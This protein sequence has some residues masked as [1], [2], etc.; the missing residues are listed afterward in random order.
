MFKQWRQDDFCDLEH[1]RKTKINNSKQQIKRT[2]EPLRS[3][4]VFV[5]CTTQTLH[6]AFSAKHTHRAELST[7]RSCRSD[8]RRIIEN[9]WENIVGGK[10]HPSDMSV[11]SCCDLALPLLHKWDSLQVT[12]WFLEELYFCFLTPMRSLM[13]SYG[14]YIS[15]A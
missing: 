1:I 5:I 4:S 14:S 2:L 15:L 8:T 3:R 13:A 7:T 11:P 10:S 6:N 9:K 12:V